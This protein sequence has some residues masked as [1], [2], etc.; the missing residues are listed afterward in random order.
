MEL[1]AWAANS[2]AWILEDD[3]DSEFR[4]AG[5]PLP[6]LKSLDRGHRVLYAGTFSK[7]LFPSLRLGY[8]VVPPEL[9]TSFL[10]ASRLLTAGQPVLQ[11]AVVAAFMQ[12]GHFARHIRRMR[13]LYAERRSALAAAMQAS[14]GPAVTIELAAGGM[15]LLAKFPHGPDDSVLARRATASGLALSALSAHSVAHGHGQGLLLSFTNIPAASAAMAVQHL[16]HALGPIGDAGP[17]PAQE[18]GGPAK[19][20][21]APAQIGTAE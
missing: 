11:Q 17:I 18:S 21:G 13:T 3:Y 20:P 1:L 4:Y 7:V 16:R 8:L 14:F 10:R 5:R 12:K 9:A 19:G 15:H 6:A 2:A